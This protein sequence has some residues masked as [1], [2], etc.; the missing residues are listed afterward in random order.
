MPAK[1]CCAWEDVRIICTINL[2]LLPSKQRYRLPLRRSLPPVNPGLGSPH[3]P[4]LLKRTG[5]GSDDD[6]TSVAHV[7]VARPTANGTLNLSDT[8]RGITEQ[9]KPGCV[10]LQ[11]REAPP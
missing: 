9:W 6:A 8:V 7:D 3:F 11:D 5:S 2:Y 4:F 1:G 10:R